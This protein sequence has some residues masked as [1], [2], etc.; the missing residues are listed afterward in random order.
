[1]PV[2]SPKLGTSLT[3]LSIFDVLIGFFHA[4]VLSCFGVFFKAKS[5]DLFWC[6]RASIYSFRAR[7]G[8]VRVLGLSW[9][10][11]KIVSVPSRLSSIN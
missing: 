7:V 3:N 4:P 5:L 10:S 11:F 6:E 9:D 1:M 2:Y 8:L